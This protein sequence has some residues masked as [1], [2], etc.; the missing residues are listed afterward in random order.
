MKLQA[1]AGSTS[2]RSKQAQSE[3]LNAVSME[4]TLCWDEIPY[5]VEDNYRITGTFWESITEVPR[6]SGTGVAMF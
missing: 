1:A 6:S 4:L 2:L 5:R 3:V